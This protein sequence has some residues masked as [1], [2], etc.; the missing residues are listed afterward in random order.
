VGKEEGNNVLLGRKET[1]SDEERIEK[2][3]K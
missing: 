3:K 1:L 2:L